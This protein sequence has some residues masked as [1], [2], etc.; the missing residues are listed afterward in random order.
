MLHEGLYH[1][2]T[3]YVTLTYDDE[4]L[5]ENKQ[6]QKR[7]LVLTFKK[8]RNQIGDRHIKYY[9]T[10]EY[11]DKF[12]R[13]H[14]HAIIFGMKRCTKCRSCIPKKTGQDNPTG[15][16]KIIKEAWENGFVETSGLGYES[17]RYVADYVQK[18]LYG[19]MAKNDKREQPFAIMSQGIGKQF[20]LDNRELIVT[21]KQLTIDGARVKIPRY[22]LKTL[23]LTGEDLYKEEIQQHIEKMNQVSDIHGIQGAMERLRDS[24]IQREKNLQTGEE[25]WKKGSM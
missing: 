8:I 17:A 9:A 24:R 6:L 5:P 4:H 2:D 14:Y 20:A 13:P 11:G 1:E 21:Y 23:G 22:Y 16:C 18:K 25:L 19:K 7:A 3:I 10:G 15:D 12:K